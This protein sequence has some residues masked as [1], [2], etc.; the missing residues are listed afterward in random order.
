MSRGGGF[1]SSGTGVEMADASSQG[2]DH[3][4]GES[5]PTSTPRSFSYR[6]DPGNDLLLGSRRSSSGSLFGSRR[7][8]TDSIL[9]SRRGSGTAPGRTLKCVAGQFYPSSVRNCSVSCILRA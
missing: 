4:G 1:G 7:Q 8:S 3:V 5:V 6:L 9:G 2:E